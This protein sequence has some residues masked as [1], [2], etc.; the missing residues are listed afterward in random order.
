MSSVSGKL[1]YLLIIDTLGPA[2]PGKAQKQ[3][4]AIVNEQE[5]KKR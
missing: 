5:F 4:A 1:N 2:K 3:G